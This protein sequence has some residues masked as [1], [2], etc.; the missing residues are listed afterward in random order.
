MSNET[1]VLIT[2]YSEPREAF[3]T[4]IFRVEE[5]F[6]CKYIEIFV[7]RSRADEAKKIVEIVKS[8]LEGVEIDVH[9]LFPDPSDLSSFNGLVES[10]FKV[11]K[12]LRERGR[13]VIAVFTGSRLE[14][15]TTVLA[16]SRVREDIVLVYIPFFW[17]CFIVDNGA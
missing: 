13:I 6:N 5:I 3:L 15:S 1:C 2:F 10:L 11:L 7:S 4:S 9:P 16:A 12:G 17:G 14:V 8:F